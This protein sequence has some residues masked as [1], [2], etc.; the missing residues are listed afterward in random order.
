MPQDR[1]AILTTAIVC[2][3]LTSFVGG[4]VSGGLYSR[5][6]G[7]RWI[8]AMLL[9]AGL[10]PGL[11]FGIAFVLNMIAVSYHSLAAVPFGT[12]VIVLLLW[13]FLSFPL[14]IL[15]GCGELGSRARAWGGAVGA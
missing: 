13:A 3:A 11:V 4:Y 5:M 10:Y 14:G 15:G 2:Y 12:I 8:A 9:T 7:K 6:E 1:G